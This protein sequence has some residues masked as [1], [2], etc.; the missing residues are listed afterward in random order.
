MTD[1]RRSSERDPDAQRL[2][3]NLIELLNEL[4]VTGTG[5]QVLLAFC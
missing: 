5:I 4:R 3:R 1:T 2:D